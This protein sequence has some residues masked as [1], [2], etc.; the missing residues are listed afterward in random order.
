[1]RLIKALSSKRQVEMLSV[2]LHRPYNFTML[3]QDKYEEV[4]Y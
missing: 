4:L 3:D 1:M 2:I